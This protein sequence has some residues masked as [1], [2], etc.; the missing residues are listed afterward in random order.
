MMTMTDLLPELHRLAK[1]APERCRYIEPGSSDYHPDSDDQFV[2]LLNSDE[3]FEEM[4]PLYWPNING[5]EPHDRDV[6]QVLLALLQEIEVRGW[7]WDHSGGGFWGSANAVRVWVAYSCS[8]DQ[9]YEGTSQL[10]F[11]T[12]LCRAFNDACEAG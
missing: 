11:V 12:A 1:N 7:P 4:D 2:V 6:G 10:A 8:F 9:S 3:S 5:R